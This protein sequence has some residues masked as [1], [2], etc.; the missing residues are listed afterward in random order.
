M[1][2][3]KETE[4]KES[5]EDRIKRERA[6]ERTKAEAIRAKLATVAGLLGLV[7][8]PTRDQDDARNPA[9]ELLDPK[10]QDRAGLWLRCDT[11]GATA[12]K[13]CAC[14]GVYPRNADGS[15]CDV[16]EYVN[17]SKVPAPLIAFSIT[18]T[19]EQIAKDIQKRFLPDYIA[20]LEKVRARIAST[21]DYDTRTNNT[22]AAILGREPDD[23]ERAKRACSVD[24]G[25]LPGE[26]YETRAYAKV[27]RESIDLELHN[28]N[29]KTA[30]AVLA[31]VR[32]AANNA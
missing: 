11:Y 7:M 30:L 31:L 23:H 9:A 24:L 20:R 19:P 26:E 12:W 14:S 27:S 10:A 16:S 8:T 5:W 28:L 4:Q 1:T 17:G 21:N 22:L 32:K 18:K 15:Y 3:Q 13:R 29:L 2:D 6:E 25:T